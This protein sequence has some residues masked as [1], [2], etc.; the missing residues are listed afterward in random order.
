MN[1]SNQN[2]PW[3]FLSLLEPSPK[4]CESNLVQGRTMRQGPISKVSKV[5]KSKVLLD[6]KKD[7]KKEEEQALRAKKVK[8][9]IRCIK[10]N[11]C[12]HSELERREKNLQRVT[13]L[14]A[15]LDRV[16][17]NKESRNVIA[18]V[19]K[20]LVKAINLLEGSVEQLQSTTNAYKMLREEFLQ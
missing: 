18:R 16:L 4:R 20:R 13:N 17:K 2:D 12:Y 1:E 19:E 3:V 15:E 11:Q 10:H 14:M 9:A 5:S 7:A 6:L 8:M